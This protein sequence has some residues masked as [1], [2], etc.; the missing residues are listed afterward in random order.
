[1][2]K[3]YICHYLHS[4]YLVSNEI[5]RYLK[6]HPEGDEAT[7]YLS[8]YAT[9]DKYSTLSPD[10]GVLVKLSLCIK[11]QNND[12]HKRH[13]GWYIFLYFRENNFHSMYTYS[14]SFFF[15]PLFYILNKS[16]AN[17]IYREVHQLG[18]GEIHIARRFQWSVQRVSVEEQVHY[19]SILH[20]Y[21]IIKS[22]IKMNGY[23]LW[24][25]SVFFSIIAKI[26]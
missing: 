4:S 12:N 7:N 18:M 8:L 20:R 10:S 15:S 25:W 1:M 19:R 3:L 5:C 13:T 24:L 21:W 9:L 6:L 23:G 26:K 16:S 11:D 22:K 2:R 14:Y 17:S